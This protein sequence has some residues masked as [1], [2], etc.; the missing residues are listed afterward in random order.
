MAIEGKL[1]NNF[2][3]EVVNDSLVEKN[4]DV[5]LSEE[6]IL[7]DNDFKKIDEQ[8]YI[9]N[10]FRN[11]AREKDILILIHLNEEHIPAQLSF[12]DLKANQIMLKT[13]SKKI[14]NETVIRISIVYK[15]ELL[16]FKSKII[17]LIDNSTYEITKPDI[18]FSSIRRYISRY[19]VNEHEDITVQ[20][21]GDSSKYQIADI[22]TKGLSFLSKSIIRS[23]ENITKSLNIRI[24]DTEILV[25][26]KFKYCR[27]QRDGHYITGMSFQNL[28]WSDYYFLFFYI[29]SND[30]SHLKYL[31]DFTSEEIYNLFEEAGYLGL[32]PREEIDEI[33]QDLI[34]NIVIIKDKTQISINP[35]FFKDGKLLST[36]S[37]LRIYDRTFLGHQLAAV[38]EARLIPK[39]KSDIYLGFADIL[40]NHP[41]FEYYLSYILD[42]PWHQEM[43]KKIGE[44]IRDKNKFLLDFIQYFECNI[45]ECSN[46]N[47]YVWNS[48]CEVVERADEFIE[49]FKDKNDPI[50]V[51]SY[52]YL[53]NSFCL[54]EIKQAYELLGLY[55]D[56]KLW[57]VKK[58][59]KV[60][61]YIVA[62][63]YSNGL[64]LFN[65]LD[66]CRIYFTDSNDVNINYII[67]EMIPNIAA[68]Y[69]SYKKKKF[70][71]M[72]KCSNELIKE[73]NLNGLKYK[74]QFGRIIISKEGVAEYKKF[75]SINFR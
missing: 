11:F 2:N 35:V 59:K 20:F 75:V 55:V 3:E 42:L 5:V 74:Y 33:F 37:L 17:E 14:N 48:N 1:F 63:V 73:I 39:S 32:K 38:P 30:Y 65:V 15:D 46:K 72:F 52:S 51:N 13:S 67:Q 8:K 68:Y 43:F 60:M 18:I 26:G 70:N 31:A 6:D 27:K 54:P 49:F 41:Y 24:K 16:F 10:L 4:K 28:R 56:R 7:I 58:G 36:A 34:R 9:N 40:L 21:L 69:Q 44:I 25:D 61:A 64:N 47:N 57:R 62:E 29:F 66:M 50:I 71:I 22:S 19:K 23:E 12:S 53:I 45:I